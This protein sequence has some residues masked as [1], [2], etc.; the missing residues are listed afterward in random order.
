MFVFVVAT[1]VM[2]G[3]N[4]LTS[5]DLAYSVYVFERPGGPDHQTVEEFVKHVEGPFCSSG[6]GLKTAKLAMYNFNGLPAQLATSTSLS[7]WGMLMAVLLITMLFELY[8]TGALTS[9]LPT[10]LKYSPQAERK[11]SW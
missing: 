9:Y 10:D 7:V 4:G 3:R 8:R 6:A 1:G 2:W 11:A 5:T